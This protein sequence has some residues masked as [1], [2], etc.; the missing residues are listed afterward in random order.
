MEV[1]EYDLELALALYSFQYLLHN[2]LFE[3]L[4]AK[5]DV[6]TQHLEKDCNS[7]IYPMLFQMGVTE[8][9]NVVGAKHKES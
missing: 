2:C 6:D 3:V 4:V 7:T 1:V 5:P 9:S 8:S